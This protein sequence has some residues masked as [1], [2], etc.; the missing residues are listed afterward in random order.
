MNNRLDSIRKSSISPV[1]GEVKDFTFSNANGE[2]EKESP[3]TEVKSES[4]QNT[5]SKAEVKKVSTP[6][7][8]TSKDSK[9]FGMSKKNV[10]MAAGIVLVGVGIYFYLNRK[11]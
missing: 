8:T 5:D 3:A 1:V 6:A 7:N 10:Y 11:K 4:I 9:I 2:G